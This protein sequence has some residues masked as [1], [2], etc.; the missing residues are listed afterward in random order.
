M[1][2]KSGKLTANE[3][4]VFDSSTFVREAGLCRTRS[5]SGCRSPSTS[6]SWAMLVVLLEVGSPHPWQTTR[7]GRV[8]A[9]SAPGPSPAGLPRYCRQA[10][11]LND[12][13]A[14]FDF[15]DDSE[16]LAEPAVRSHAPADSPGA[17]RCHVVPASATYGRLMPRGAFLL[18]FAALSSSDSRHFHRPSRSER[19]M[20]DGFDLH[21]IVQHLRNLPACSAYRVPL[22]RRSLDGSFHEVRHRALRE[23]L[24]P[25]RSALCVDRYGMDLRILFHLLQ[26]PVLFT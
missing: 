3:V 24:Q 19:Q 1:D 13:R 4:L 23:T 9:P 22:P 12:V 26:E 10:G 14:R 2:S 20:S 6:D 15:P 16:L 17:T 21:R 7:N 5:F 25:P 11:A 18:F 8:L